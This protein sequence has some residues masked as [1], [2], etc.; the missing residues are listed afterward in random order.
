MEIWSFFS[1]A[2]GLDLGFESA[3]LR[4]TLAVERDQWCRK[5]IALNRPDLD[6]LPEGDV[7]RI[8][9]AALRRHR[10]FDGEVTLM[11]GGPPCQSFSTGGKRSGLTDPRG[12]LI[13]TYMNL[14]RE[15]QP[16]Y[17]V[18]E[19]VANLVTAALR[20]RP[21]NERPGKHWSLKKYAGQSAPTED[22]IVPLEPDELSGSAI[23]QLLTDFRELGYE[24]NFGVLNSAD[25][26]APQKRQRLVMLG[27]RGAAPPVL[28]SPT[29]KPRA[30]ATVRNAIEDLRSNPGPHSEYTEEVA[31]FFKLVPEGGTW[32]SLPVE[33]QR[34]ALGPSFDAG[35]GKTGFFRRLA[36]DEPAP[37]VTGRMNRKASAMCHPELV[38]PIS[39]RE[40]ARLQGFPDEWQFSGAMS[41]QYLQIGNAVPVHLGAAVGRAILAH[42]NGESG[43][44]ED[45]DV[46]LDR[47]VHTL[48]ASARNK[49]SQSDD[50]G[51]ESEANV[52][53]DIAASEVPSSPKPRKSAG[54]GKAK[55]VQ[56]ELPLFREVG[57][58]AC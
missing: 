37:T 1:G 29:R 30:Y 7:T 19:N 38:R 46:Q 27:A 42:L 57:G 5:T 44:S 21:I 20:H 25:F 35:G 2:M 11:V 48:R 9:G 18:L 49:R 12:N 39:V 14:I 52:S 10:R 6:L 28:P 53:C 32:R 15:V 23:R 55:P 47:A 40:S 31:R 33:L 41:S 4:P 22:G 56:A 3:G 17:F 13:Y 45:W 50:E 26:G 16:R 51:D 34:E 43:R 54:R 8:D 58:R 36:W 24:I